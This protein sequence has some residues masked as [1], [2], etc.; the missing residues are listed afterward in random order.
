MQLILKIL[1]YSKFYFYIS[2]SISS[3]ASNY[4][5]MGEEGI[6]PSTPWSQTKIH[7]VER[8]TTVSYQARPPSHK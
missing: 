8:N 6:E 1:H 4:K 5:R 7:A 3:I 2:K